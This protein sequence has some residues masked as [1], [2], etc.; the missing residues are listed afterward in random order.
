MLLGEG[1][2]DILLGG[3]ARD[4]LIGGSTTQDNDALR[5]ILDEWNAQRDF[6]SRVENILGTGTGNRLNGTSFLGGGAVFNDGVRDVLKGARGTDLLI[7]EDLDDIRGQN[8]VS[9]AAD[10]DLD[11]D[12]LLMAP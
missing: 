5:T 1:D 3:S 4:I 12:L 7:A 8:T 6:V 10:V 9:D 11:V 2:A